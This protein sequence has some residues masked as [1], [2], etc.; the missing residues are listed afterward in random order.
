MTTELIRVESPSK[1]VFIV[2]MAEKG[3][4]FVYKIVEPQLRRIVQMTFDDRAMVRDVMQADLVL[5]E[6]ALREGRTEGHCFAYQTT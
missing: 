3:R 4:A 5:E 6:L 2:E 1:R